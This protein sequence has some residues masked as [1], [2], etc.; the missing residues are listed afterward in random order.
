MADESEIYRNL[1]VHLDK[2]PIGFP[3][4]KSGVEIRILKHLFTPEEA[5]L[6]CQLSMIAEPLDQI[7]DRLDKS[8]I[9][10][11]E[12]ERTLDRMA[13]KGSITSRKMADR[14]SYSLIPFVVGMYEQ[15][16]DRLTKDF[17]GDVKL[18]LEGEYGDE[19][20]RTK[21]PQLRTIPVRQSIATPEK[22]SVSSYDDIRHIIENADGQLGVINCICRQIRNAI[23]ESCTKTDL[24]EACIVFRWHADGF[25]RRG[26]G[27]SITKD[28]ALAILDKAQEAGLVL[29][30]ANTQRPLGLCCCCGDCCGILT[31]VKRYPR[32]A[33]LYAS[34]YYAEVDPEL[35][36]GCE[37]CISRCQLDAITIPD[38]VAVV[39]LDRCIGCGNCVASCDSD[40]AQLRKKETEMVPPKGAG[41]LYMKIMAKKV[42]K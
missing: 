1:Q 31:T 21:I 29:Q 17:A 5:E 2:L 23:G 19:M 42:S 28:E 15:Q 4:T 10:V 36:T 41:D 30:P 34:N 16:V 14:K 7:Y 22:F 27:R 32:P 13:G 40:A 24:H 9:A 35:C 6:A 25:L 37:I 12:L 11:D 18:Y 38:D 3:S 20:Y 39:D 8:K 33:E 26:I